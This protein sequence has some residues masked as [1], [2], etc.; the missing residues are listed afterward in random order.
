MVQIA[1]WFLLLTWSALTLAS[2]GC[3]IASLVINGKLHGQGPGTF[4][5][6]I[7][8]RLLFLAILYIAGAFSTIF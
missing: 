3:F 2:V 1:Q 6:A 8:T 5:S 7:I 4:F